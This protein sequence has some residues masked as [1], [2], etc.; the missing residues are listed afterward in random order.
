MICAMQAA[1]Y[2]G[3]Q[4]MSTVTKAFYHQGRQQVPSIT[5]D[6]IFSTDIENITHWLKTSRF[7]LERLDANATL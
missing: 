5:N 7:T 4:E 2:R 1:E 3:T 6:R